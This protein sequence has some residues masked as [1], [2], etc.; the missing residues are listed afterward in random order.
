MNTLGDRRVVRSFNASNENYV[1][2]AKAMC[3]AIIDMLDSIP[4]GNSE[5]G[6]WKALAMTA[7]EEGCMWWVK[8]LTAGQ[9]EEKESA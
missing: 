9:I 3:A 7:I 2:D 1:G 8:A 5:C 6:R 4:E